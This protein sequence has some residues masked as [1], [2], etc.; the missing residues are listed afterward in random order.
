MLSARSNATNAAKVTYNGETKR[1][2]TN[3]DFEELV[4]R[5]RASFTEL[6]EAT[7]VKFFYVD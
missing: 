1:V 6:P 3:G 5:T 7:P 2:S 4:S